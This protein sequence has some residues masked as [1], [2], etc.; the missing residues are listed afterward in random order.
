MDDPLIY[1]MCHR[2]TA[3][4]GEEIIIERKIFQANNQGHCNQRRL[5]EVD[6][7]KIY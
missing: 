1:V 2:S 7:I 3:L 5:A 4:K 6:R